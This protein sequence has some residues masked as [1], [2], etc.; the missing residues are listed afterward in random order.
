MEVPL[1]SRIDWIIMSSFNVVDEALMKLKIAA[2]LMG[3]IY[4][5][6]QLNLA[7]HIALSRP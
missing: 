2:S 3:D 7:W 5:P 6:N 1:P 4:E